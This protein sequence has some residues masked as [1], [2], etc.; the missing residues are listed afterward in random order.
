MKSQF[1]EKLFYQL[2]E[3]R[4]RPGQHTYQNIYGKTLNPLATGGVMDISSK[5]DFSFCPNAFRI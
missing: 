5:Y 3:S 4:H 2:L 1:L